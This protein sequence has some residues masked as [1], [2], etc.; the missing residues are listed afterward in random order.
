MPDG[1]RE[2]Y[3][4]VD[5]GDRGSREAPEDQVRL[6]INVGVRT[7][8]SRDDL[9]SFIAEKA[10]VDVDQ[11]HRVDLKEAFSF[12]NIAAEVEQKVLDGI[13]GEDFNGRSVRVERAK[14]R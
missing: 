12:V 1:E 6:F 13:A 2:Q 3:D 8:A 10:G 4:L 5:R 9:S 14:S 11:V 7:G